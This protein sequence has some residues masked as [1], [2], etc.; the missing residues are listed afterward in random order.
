M[1]MKKYVTGMQRMAEL[2]E[3]KE[4]ANKEEKEAYKVKKQTYDLLPNAEEN[5]TKLQVC[6]CVHL[7]V[8]GVTFEGV[9]SLLP[10]L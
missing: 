5:I 7:H 8:W 1:N 9:A 3:Q 2:Q 6:L 4:K 10:R